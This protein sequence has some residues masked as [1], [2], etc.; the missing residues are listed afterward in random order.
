MDVHEYLGRRKQAEEDL[1]RELS[2]VIKTHADKLA[3]ETG[4]M[5]GSVEVDTQL[6]AH[7]DQ[8]LPVQHIE[9][10]VTGIAVKMRSAMD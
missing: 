2:L 8:A 4:V 10:F 6:V 5:V 1:A 3:K 9:Q 7:I